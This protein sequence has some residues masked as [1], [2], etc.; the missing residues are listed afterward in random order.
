MNAVAKSIHAT[1]LSRA[2]ALIPKL[3][4]AL[5]PPT[6]SERDAAL[7]RLF[8]RTSFGC[9]TDKVIELVSLVTDYKPVPP[10]KVAGE[11]FTVLYCQSNGVFWVVLFESHGFATLKDGTYHVDAGCER[12][13]TQEEA[14]K[15][16]AGFADVD[17]EKFLAWV[18]S[19][20][21]QGTKWIVDL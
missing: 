7:D 21:S 4:V 16:L 12:L 5:A 6:R 20:F 17:P 1:I 11:P 15:F 14:R 9:N 8:A 18:S 2:T 13:A 10:A 19:K 3:P